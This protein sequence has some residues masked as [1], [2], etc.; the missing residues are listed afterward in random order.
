MSHPIFT[1]CSLRAVSTHMLQ[2]SR[3]GVAENS[4]C[5][6]Y[7]DPWWHPFQ[8][9][10][11][12]QVSSKTC[13]SWI[14]LWAWLRS[15]AVYLLLNDNSQSNNSNC[16]VWREREEGQRTSL[17]FSKIRTSGVMRKL[18]SSWSREYMYRG[19]WKICLILHRPL[20]GVWPSTEKFFLWNSA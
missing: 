9:H 15:L 16:T 1:F 18:A 4:T 13:L 5:C 6:F 17:V 3:R 19:T 2:V 20:L 10:F 14:Q 12:N 11:N 8:V 7:G